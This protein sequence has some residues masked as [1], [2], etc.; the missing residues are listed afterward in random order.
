MRM[1]AAVLLSLVLP[2]RAWALA[3]VRLI[4]SG[5]EGTT[6][7]AALSLIQDFYTLR[8]EN[9]GDLPAFGVV[10]SDTLP[11]NTAFQQLTSVPPP[12]TCTAPAQG[13]SGGT[14]T[15]NVGTLQPGQ[16]LEITFTHRFTVGIQPFTITNTANATT[17]S[18]ENR[19]D[20]NSDMTVGNVVPNAFP[21]QIPAFSL[22]MLFLLAAALAIGGWLKTR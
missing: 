6:S 20:N 5:T 17:S 8:V 2:C 10:V 15:C 14:V 18:A 3:D 9:I 4:K 13:S 19:T 1:L 16:L 7:A 12:V 22:A 11:T 21:A